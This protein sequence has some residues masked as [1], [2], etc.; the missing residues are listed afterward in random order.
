M[1]MY[2]NSVEWNESA[3]IPVL[4]SRRSSNSFKVFA[5][6]ALVA[7]IALI[8]FGALL[9]TGCAILPVAF[10]FGAVFVGSSAVALISRFLVPLLLKPEKERNERN[11]RIIFRKIQ[12]IN[13]NLS[14]YVKEVS[15]LI[16]KLK[17]GEDPRLIADQMKR[18]LES[19]PE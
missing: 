8:C 17:R 4:A 14:D 16:K 12:I 19:G 1:A 6:S 10:I 15:P 13:Q 18:L 11:L 7:S 2:T 5:I 3:H 9:F